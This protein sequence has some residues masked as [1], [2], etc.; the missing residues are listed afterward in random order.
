[1]SNPANSLGTNA[2]YSGYTSVEAFNDVLS[3]FQGRGILSGWVVA[4]ISGM[5]VRLASTATPRSVAIAENNTGGLTTINTP[6]RSATSINL[7]TAPSSGTSYRSIVLYVNNPPTATNTTV[8]NPSA[9]GFAIVSSTTSASPSD[10]DI[11]AAITNDGGTGSTAYYVIAATIAIPAGTT[12]VTANMI[13]QGARASLKNQTLPWLAAPLV[14]T[15]TGTTNLGAFTGNTGQIV[16]GIS[17]TISEDGLYSISLQS[18]SV[19]TGTAKGGFNSRIMLNGTE[20]KFSYFESATNYAGNN[21]VHGDQY[22]TIY[23]QAGDVLSSSLQG[24]GNI[25]NTNVEQTLT[26]TRSL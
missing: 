11:R 2:A 7:G 26:L 15:F 23:L 1:M 8:D 10:S 14:T 24:F 3:A 4:P 16:N 20:I 9:V 22:A 25:P 18:A 5:L 13:T 21:F 12:T 19:S 17:Q 6:R